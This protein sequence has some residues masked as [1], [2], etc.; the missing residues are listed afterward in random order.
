MSPRFSGREIYGA[1]PFS[2]S[3]QL[4]CSLANTRYS[5]YETYSECT[6]YMLLILFI[7]S[8]KSFLRP[9]ISYLCGGIPFESWNSLPSR[10]RSLVQGLVTSR[11]DY[12]NA[13][14]YGLPPNQLKRL[15]HVQNT[16]AR[17]VTRTRRRDHITPVLISLH[18]IPVKYRI[19]YKIILY[20]FK[21]LQGEAPVYMTDMVRKTHHTT[22][23]S[24][25]K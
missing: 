1:V 19:E 7:L 20:V 6:I 23:S 25:T 12:C 14:L 17:I 11:L 15:Q 24:L 18:W 21:A 3:A 5:I 9:L 2:R 13:L 22:G 4:I 16:A 10:T 8:R